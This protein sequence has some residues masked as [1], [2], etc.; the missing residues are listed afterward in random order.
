MT[1]KYD[2]SWDI[3][4]ID[5]SQS[6]SINVGGND[7]RHAMKRA[8]AYSNHK[9]GSSWWRIWSV[10]GTVLLPQGANPEEAEGKPYRYRDGNE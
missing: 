1:K 9:Y 6:V 4:V 8:I 3:V 2:K 7:E 5:G 10:N